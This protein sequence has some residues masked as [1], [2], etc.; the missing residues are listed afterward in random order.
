MK[1]IM[2]VFFSFFIFAN[3][4]NASQSNYIK[5]EKS[6][7]YIKG[8]QR[9][10]ERDYG[11]GIQWNEDY[12]V[13]AKHVNFV[14]G[15]VYKSSDID[16][17]FVKHKSEGEIPS[18]RERVPGENIIVLGNSHNGT[19]SVTGNDLNLFSETIYGLLYVNNA[20]VQHGQS[21]GP[22]FGSDG[23]VIGMTIAMFTGKQD[24]GKPIPQLNGK[25]KYF[26]MYL[27]YEEIQKEWKKYQ[28]SL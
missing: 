7:S 23:K 25:G 20:P 26:S 12:M 16:L 22:V 18:W 24:D 15:V 4:C 9:I 5:I 1:K 19:L 8:N 13:T 11:S 10:T 14:N 17:Q 21:G 27:P 6:I 2:V 3:S 28:N